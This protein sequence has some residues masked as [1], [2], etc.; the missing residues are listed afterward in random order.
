MDESEKIARKYIRSMYGDVLLYEPDGNVPPDF[1]LDGR[2]AIEVRRLNKNFESP[3][4]HPEGIENLSMSLWTSIKKKLLKFGPSIDGESWIVWVTFGRP[5]SDLKTVPARIDHKLSVFKALLLR[6]PTKIPIDSNLQIELVRCPH[7]N[8]TFF[9]LGGCS[10]NDAG[11]WVLG[12]VAENLKLC[13]VE[14][15]AKIMPYRYR[16]PEW[17]LVLVDHIDFGVDDQDHG[18]LREYLGSAF[19]H[20]W[21]K[22]ILLDPRNHLRAFEI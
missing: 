16:Y 6:Q 13:V 12:E 4:G 20:S 19:Q 2:V 21:N 10:D 18:L 7:D 8:S 1:L 22:I 11:G 14:K 17:W 9:S 15:E 5:I 3:N